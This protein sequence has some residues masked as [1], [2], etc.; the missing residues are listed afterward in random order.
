[1][2]LASSSCWQFAL[3]QNM[4]TGLTGAQFRIAVQLRNDVPCPLFNLASFVVAT[5]VEINTDV[6]GRDL[7]TDPSSIA[8]LQCLI[9]H[10]KLTPCGAIIASC[11]VAVACVDRH[12][13]GF[14]VSLFVAPAN[15]LAEQFQFLRNI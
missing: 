5:F 2:A 11:V 13:S 8:R 1:M 7:E 14:S 3:D 10:F 12:F 6:R 4:N 15:P 9:G